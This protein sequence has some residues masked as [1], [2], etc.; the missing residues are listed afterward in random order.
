MSCNIC[1]VGDSSGSTKFSI[2]FRQ[3]HRRF[4]LGVY[5]IRWIHAT[6]GRLLAQGCPYKLSPLYP[7]SAKSM[8]DLAIAVNIS[9]KNISFFDAQNLFTM[10]RS[11]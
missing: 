5:S 4:N 1:V 7:V 10:Y 3:R 8:L 6:T 2:V 11:N 9:T